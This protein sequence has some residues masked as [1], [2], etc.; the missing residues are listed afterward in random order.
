MEIAKQHEAAAIHRGQ[1]A[2][3]ELMHGRAGPLQLVQKLAV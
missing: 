2:A 3:Q 1:V